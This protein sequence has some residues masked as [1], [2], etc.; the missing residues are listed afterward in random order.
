MAKGL[1]I[2]YL[3]AD[4]ESEW[5]CSQWRALTPANA[6]NSENAAGR[7]AH[8]AKLYHLGSAIDWR[9]PRVE[10]ALGMANVMVFQRNVI[11][12]EVWQAMDY[13][14][15]LG[16]LVLVDLDDHY[17]ELPPS[18][19]A[20]EYWTRN[21][22]EMQ[23]DPIARLEEGM[24]HADYLISPSKVILQDWASVVPGRWF[25][26]WTQ[27]PWYQSVQ[28][29]PLGAPDV[30]VRSGAP[31]KD[32][33]GA[34][35]PATVQA[36]ERAG[37]AGEII[38]GWGGSVSHVDSWV[39]SGIVDALD[40]IFREFPQVRLKFCG[41]E[42]RLDL[43]LDRWGDKVIRQPGVT[44]QDWPVVVSTFDIGVAPLDVR[45]LVPVWRAGA[46]EASYDERRSWLKG[47]EYLCAGVP[48]IGQRSA[49]YADLSS[50]G[51][52]VDATP[53]S[54]Y[55]ALSL[56]IRRLAEAKKLAADNRRWALKRLTFEANVNVY[57]EMLSSMFAERETARGAQLPG[58]I[59]VRREREK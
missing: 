59:Y 55:E 24:R 1:H 48:W 9:D 26:N 5:N 20:H 18:N 51:T 58:V 39:Y 27:L 21:V 44:A 41:S 25:P 31:S 29:K 16:K 7:T 38:I 47:I 45:P 3:Y 33:G 2:L 34:D 19:P 23:P 53:D 57:G 56:K 43:I 42:R 12:P 10:Q 35:V 40:R 30:I 14:R 11:S 8:T 54:W 32:S 46:P 6:I 15:A 4:G 36:S 49:T 52:L 17:P 28:Q 50:R 22:L 37:S 13:W